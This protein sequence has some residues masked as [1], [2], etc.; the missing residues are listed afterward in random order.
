MA[1]V[2]ESSMR[3]PRLTLSALALLAASSLAPAADLLPA[4]KSVHEAIDHYIDAKLREEGV[5]PAAQADDATLIRRLTLDLVGRIPTAA[6]VRA[7]VASTEPD[8]RA[9]LV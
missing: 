5:K 7:Y 1:R 4:G 3:T 8:K 2:E 6:E 9:T